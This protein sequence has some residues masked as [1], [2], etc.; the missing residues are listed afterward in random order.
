[1]L[2]LSYLFLDQQQKTL[3]FMEATLTWTLAA[4]AGPDGETVQ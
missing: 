4:T 3:L 1:M 2:E